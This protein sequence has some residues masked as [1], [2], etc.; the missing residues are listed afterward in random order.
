MRLYIWLLLAWCAGCAHAT[1]HLDPTEPR[2]AGT[3]RAIPSSSA[4]EQLRI[5]SFN[6]K[7]GEAVDQALALLRDTPGLAGADLIAL[8]EMDDVGVRRIAAG[9]GLHY[10]YYPAVTQSSGRYF[11]NALLSRWPIE[12]DGKLILPA[13][14]VV[15]G[16]QRIAVR[17]TLRVG[18]HRIRVYSVH[19]ASLLDVWPPD[20]QRQWATVLEDADST[21][22]PIIIAGDING[23]DPG[24]EAAHRDFVRLT[25][26]TGASHLRFSLDQIFVRGIEPIAGQ[27]GRVLV[28]PELSDHHAVWA[29]VRVP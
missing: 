13:R 5:V 4:P 6:L 12:Q 2:M 7:H 9:L 23:E 1:N 3:G 10:V 25:A 27:A 15:H 20:Q 26:G 18:P 28:P 16:S 19:L 11:G 22:L 17:G 14:S 21:R 24:G 8:Q 29:L